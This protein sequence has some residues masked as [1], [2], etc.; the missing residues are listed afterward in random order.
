MIPSVGGKKSGLRRNPLLASHM[1]S[2]RGLRQ[3]LPSI[4]PAFFKP[5]CQGLCVLVFSRAYGARRCYESSRIFEGPFR[6]L[7]NS[8]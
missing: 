4:S 3:I 8:G 5:L 7:E 1:S 2:P 6:P